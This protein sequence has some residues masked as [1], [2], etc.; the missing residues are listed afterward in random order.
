MDICMCVCIH[1][2][3]HI[4][5]QMIPPAISALELLCKPIRSGPY[6]PQNLG[7]GISAVTQVLI[8]LNPF[9]GLKKRTHVGHAWENKKWLPSWQSMKLTTYRTLPAARGI[10]LTKMKVSCPVFGG[11]HITPWGAHCSVGEAFANAPP[12]PSHPLLQ[13]VTDHFFTAVQT[14]AAGSKRICLKSQGKDRVS[15]FGIAR[16]RSFSE[17]LTVFWEQIMAYSDCSVQSHVNYGTGDLKNR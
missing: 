4:Q 6:T 1:I 17:N 3:K 15:H 12:H 14:V 2:S 8:Q 11:C 7:T 9:L 5:T 13:K 16:L 10:P